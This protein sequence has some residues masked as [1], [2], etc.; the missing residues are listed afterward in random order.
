MW[1]TQQTY[2]IEPN[3]H[4]DR[5]Q[6]KERSSTSLSLSLSLSPV[7][8]EKGKKTDLFMCGSSSWVK[9]NCNYGYVHKM[10][11][12]MCKI[13]PCKYKQ[14]IVSHFAKTEYSHIV[15]N[16]NILT[17]CKSRIFPHCAKT[18][19]SHKVYNQNVLTLCKRRIFSRGAQSEHAQIVDNQN[20]LIGIFPIVPL[21]KP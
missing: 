21:Y 1:K 2:G 5:S 3:L 16:Q 8:C 7:T 10:C 12:Y 20:I 17:L 13:C 14:I 15:H 6:S 11:P 19:Y 4:S 9:E 18:E